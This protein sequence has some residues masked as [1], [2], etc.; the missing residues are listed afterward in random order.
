MYIIYLQYL[1]YIQTKLPV[2]YS[3]LVYKFQKI[4]GKTDFPYHF[5]GVVGGAKVLGKLPVS[6]RPTSLDDSRAR[7]YF[8]CSR[9]GWGLPGY[10]SLIYH[11]SFLFLP[12]SGRRPDID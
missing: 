11:F 6:G 1:H 10:F 3:D 9:C 7:A 2:F 4:I 5:K 8:A 12:L